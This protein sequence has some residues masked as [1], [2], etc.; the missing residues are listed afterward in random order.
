MNMPI[1]HALLPMNLNP[2]EAHMPVG[3]NASVGEAVEDRTEVS[4]MGHMQS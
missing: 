2:Q 3:K 4:R 1:F